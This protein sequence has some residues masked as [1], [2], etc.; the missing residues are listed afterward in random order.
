MNILATVSFGKNQCTAS[1]ELMEISGTPYIRITTDK[2]GNP[3]LIKL[4]KAK[5]QNIA[6]IEA[7]SKHY[8]GTANASDAFVLKGA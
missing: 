2:D 3:L 4:D 1:W 8:L 5:L 7:A 6:G